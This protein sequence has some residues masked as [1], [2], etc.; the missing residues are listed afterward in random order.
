MLDILSSAFFRCQGDLIRFHNLS[1]DGSS[2]IIE[3][4]L[5]FDSQTKISAI[6]SRVPHYARAHPL[7]SLLKS[8][9]K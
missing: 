6:S 5:R 2:E 8:S 7:S 4:F 3:E 1:A 9:P